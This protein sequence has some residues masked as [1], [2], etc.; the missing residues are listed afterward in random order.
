MRDAPISLQQEIAF[1]DA[2]E[3]LS[4]VRISVSLSHD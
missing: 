4:K 3:I 1:D 2:Q